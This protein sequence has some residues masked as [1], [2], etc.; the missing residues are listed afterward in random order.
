[1][2]VESKDE[3]TNEKLDPS[4]NKQDESL[5]FIKGEASEPYLGP[6]WALLMLL[7][8][9]LKQFFPAERYSVYWYLQIYVL[10]IVIGIAIF[11]LVKRHRFFHSDDKEK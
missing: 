5:G 6:S 8:Y 4:E 11:T 9:V 2:D 1:M 3:L 10:L 7:L